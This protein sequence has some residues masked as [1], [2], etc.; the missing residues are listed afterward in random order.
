[1]GETLMAEEAIEIPRVTLDACPY[2][3][4]TNIVKHVRIDQTAEAGRIG[5][6]Y[7]A[8]LLFY[9]E[10]PLYA[11]LCDNCGSLVRIFV[12]KPRKKWVLK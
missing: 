8:K 3:K 5:L 9:G 1:M 11:D 2:C 6:T 12:D 10:E 7:K 4:S